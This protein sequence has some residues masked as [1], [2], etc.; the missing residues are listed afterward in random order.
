S[1]RYVDKAGT[2][3]GTGAFT[4]CVLMHQ[5][6][7]GSYIISHIARGHWGALEREQKIKALADADSK[8]FSNYEVGVEQEP[9][10]GG[11]ES[12]EAT[13]RNLAGKRVFVDRV[14]GSKEVRAEPWV[15]QVQNDNVRLVA[16]DWVFPFLSECEAWPASTHKDQVDGAAGSFN[17][18]ASRPV[19]DLRPFDP[20][21]IDDD[22]P[23]KVWR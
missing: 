6:Y 11:K 15:A 9:G 13:V 17:R 7:D 8:L 16:G 12:A 22:D 21:F 23:R 5:M 4:A 1:C 19:Y 18:L 10:S 14:T 3:G 2:E 20:N